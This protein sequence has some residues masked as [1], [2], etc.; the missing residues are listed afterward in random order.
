MQLLLEVAAPHQNTATVAAV[1]S[2][3]FLGAKLFEK[4]VELFFFHSTGCPAGSF[5]DLHRR[6]GHDTLW[7]QG[8]AD[9]M[10]HL[11]AELQSRNSLKFFE[12][13]LESIG[14]AK[15]RAGMPITARRSWGGELV[16]IGA[17]EKPPSLAC[18]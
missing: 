3:L 9:E 6:Y 16:S 11:P 7:L 17:F 12:F 5:N 13:G 4:A 10:G 15:E 2:T 8:V 14:A 18:S 1:E